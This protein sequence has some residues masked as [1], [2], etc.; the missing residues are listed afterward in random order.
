M[1]VMNFALF[2]VINSKFSVFKNTVAQDDRLVWEH[3]KVWYM[4][5][6]DVSS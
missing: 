6:Q 3:F 4:E 2:K 1:D 5:I